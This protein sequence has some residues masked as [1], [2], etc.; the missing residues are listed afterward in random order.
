MP[1]IFNLSFHLFLFSMILSGCSKSNRF[2]KNTGNPAQA[3]SNVGGE[4][5]HDASL[6]PQ[7]EPG[8]IAQGE[9]ATGPDNVHGSQDPNKKYLPNFNNPE[10]KLG[11]TIPVKPKPPVGLMTLAASSGDIVLVRKLVKAGA[12][13]D[14][15][16][17]DLQN[18][19]TPLLAALAHGH[20]DVALYLLEAGASP[21]SFFQGFTP[22]EIITLKNF[23]KIKNKL[24]IE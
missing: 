10:Q 8:G 16:I 22:M 2:Q 3:V 23:N 11:E 17:G 12:D 6:D 4:Q 21:N 1:K 9:G 24:L 19:I 18:K 15:N 13:L 14:E 7:S 20:E 5:P